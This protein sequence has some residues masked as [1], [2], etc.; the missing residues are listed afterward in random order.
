MSDVDLGHLRKW[1]GKEQVATDILTERI[2]VGLLATLDDQGA[3][4]QNGTPAPLGA[5][6]CLAPQT[7][8]MSALGHDGHPAK[9]GFLPPVPLP[10]RMW[11]GGLLEF[12]DPLLVGDTVTR[13][14]VIKDVALKNGSGGVFCIVAVQHDAHT[15]RGP[16]VRERHDIVYLPSDKGIAKAPSGDRNAGGLSRSLPD[17]KWSEEI[18]A[19]SVTLFRYSA[20]TFNGH[21]IHYDRRF[22]IEE[23]G[24]PGLVVHGPL[25]ATLLLRFAASIRDKRTPLR[26]EYRGL[27]PLFDGGKFRLNA[28]DDGDGMKL[29]SSDESGHITMS[30]AALW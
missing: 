19:D 23:E 3:A 17:A 28:I 26:F 4:P 5:H 18:V 29:W 21:R 7:E 13:H 14:S 12:F 20:L 24:Y 6:W 10:R 2:A 25:Q 15:S 9:G 8:P 30:A 27:R 11:G 1:I 22:C 16:A